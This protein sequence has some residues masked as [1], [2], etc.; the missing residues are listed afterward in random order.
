MVVFKKNILILLRGHSLKN[1]ENL[2]NREINILAKIL[3]KNNPSLHLHSSMLFLCYD[4]C[5]FWQ[6]DQ[7]QHRV[8]GKRW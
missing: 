2:D 6:P 3:A 7:L 8:K 5:F 1:F 4:E